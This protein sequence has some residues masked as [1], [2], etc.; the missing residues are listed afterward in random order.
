MA[1]QG[2]G[3]ADNGRQHSDGCDGH[4]SFKTALCQQTSTTR[5]AP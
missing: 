2:A 5:L 1:W 4:I 3:E